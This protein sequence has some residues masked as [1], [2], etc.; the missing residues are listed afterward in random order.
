MI[1][2]EGED[3]NGAW[4]DA[5]QDFIDRWVLD[6]FVS[7]KSRGV[8]ENG[9]PL[10]GVF[11]RVGDEVSATVIAEGLIRSIRQS[12]G[13]DIM[14]GMSLYATLGNTISWRRPPDA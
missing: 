5:G 2:W 14:E 12:D 8:A 6:R 9:T 13:R 7:T 4:T 1:A 11:T 3:M 10:T